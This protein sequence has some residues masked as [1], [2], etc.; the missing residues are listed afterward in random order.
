MTSCLIL[1]PKN[2]MLVTCKPDIGN[3][4]LVTNKPCNNIAKQKTNS[5]DKLRRSTNKRKNNERKDYVPVS[6]ENHE[7]KLITF[8]P[9]LQ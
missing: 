7:L 8:A 6:L 9:R 3:E 2:D 4:K 5:A 1:L